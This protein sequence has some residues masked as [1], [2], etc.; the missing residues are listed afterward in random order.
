MVT[1]SEDEAE[2]A[3]WNNSGSCGGI[4]SEGRGKPGA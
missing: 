4:A 2:R 3:A 1:A